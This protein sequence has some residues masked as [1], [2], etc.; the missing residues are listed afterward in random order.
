MHA[1]VKKVAARHGVAASAV[2]LAWTVRE[3]ATS[4]VA[5]TSRVERVREL[6]AALTLA[7]SA[8]DL[9]E[10]DAAFPAPTEDEP[11]ETI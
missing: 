3:P 2:A 8:D 5:K 1:T 4:A 11:L 6:A 9:R 7:L 10:L